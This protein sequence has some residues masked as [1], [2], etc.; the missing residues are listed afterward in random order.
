MQ[1]ELQRGNVKSAP[2]SKCKV[3]SKEPM[4]AESIIEE[5][6]GE[7][8][9]KD[10]L[11]PPGSADGGRGVGALTPIEPYLLRPCS[12]CRGAFQNEDEA[13]ECPDCG[14]PC[15]VNCVPQHRAWDHPFGVKSAPKRSNT[16][17]C[18]TKQL[19]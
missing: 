12:H 19:K 1:S 4:L 16:N 8:F 17:K 18:L 7:T 14:A 6:Y 3:S 15:H 2:K 5:F 13:T 9:G 10:A 11:P